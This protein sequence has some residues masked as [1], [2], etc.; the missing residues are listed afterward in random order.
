[1]DW[2]DRLK[3]ETEDLRYDVNKLQDFTRTKK[4]YEL[5]R[6]HKDLLYEQLHVMLSYLQIL[7]KRLELLG[8]KLEID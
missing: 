2:Q 1:M 6:E 5:D 4:F 3:K 7:G 8:I